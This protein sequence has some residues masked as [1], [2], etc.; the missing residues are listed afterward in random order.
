MS[1]FC[2]VANGI[3]A[4]ML[5]SVGVPMMTSLAPQYAGRITS[6]IES[7]AGVGVA[8]GPPMG[9]LFYSLGGYV[10]PFAVSGGIEL[11]F[12]LIAF[13]TVPS[14]VL[15]NAPKSSAADS[16]S[17]KTSDPEAINNDDRYF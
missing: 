7:G 17:R 2:R 12:T 15:Y 1:L 8:L 11:L 3:G 16:P 5:W 9:S 10:Y 6:L 13:V 4:G 14:S